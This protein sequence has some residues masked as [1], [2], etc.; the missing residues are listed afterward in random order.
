MLQPGPVQSAYSR[1]LTAAQ[2]GMP[3]STTGWDVDTKVLES[4]SAAFGLAVS[5]GT[6]DRG[7]LLGVPSGHAFVGITVMDITLANLDPTT[8]DKYLQNDN[9]AVAVR[10]DWWVTVHGAVTP[11][12][13]PTYDPVTGQLGFSGGVVIE[14]ARWMTS[15]VAGG[16]AVLRL[17]NSA[18]GQ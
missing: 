15:A 3:A 5:Q 1:Y 2:N 18:G 14:D 6:N 11:H 10:G 13:K 4:A 17:G 8:T 7:I 9:V 16:L 12:D